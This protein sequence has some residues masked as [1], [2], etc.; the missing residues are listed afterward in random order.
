[1]TYTS[2]KVGDNTDFDLSNYPSLSQE[3]SKIKTDTENV[4][5]SFKT[6]IL[7]SYA[8]DHCLKLE[9]LK[10]NPEFSGLITSGALKIGN[11]ESLFAAGRNNSMF[12]GQ[13]ESY[14]RETLH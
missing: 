4:S 14:I 2:Y 1:M 6:E 3:I 11:I 8:K 13:L 5:H 12:V 10:E 7:I 9:W